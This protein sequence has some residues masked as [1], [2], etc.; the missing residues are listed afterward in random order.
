MRRSPHWSEDDGEGASA[1]P[2]GAGLLMDR[3]NLLSPSRYSSD[4]YFPNG[5][6]FL[7]PS[8]THVHICVVGGHSVDA[9]KYELLLSVSR[10]VTERGGK[11]ELSSSFGNLS[12]GSN[13]SSASEEQQ[14]T[15]RLSDEGTEKSTVQQMPPASDFT[16]SE[17]YGGRSVTEMG[18]LEALIMNTGV[19]VSG[20]RLWIDAPPSTRC[21]WTQPAHMG[22][23][24]SAPISLHVVMSAVPCHATAMWL[25]DH[26]K[27]VDLALVL[28][29]EGDRDSWRA[30]AEID[31]L[32][33]AQPPVPRQYVCINK[34]TSINA[35]VVVTDPALDT[36]D[37][38]VEKSQGNVDEVFGLASAHTSKENLR[39]P[40][41]L[42]LLADGSFSEQDSKTA[43]EACIQV[44]LDTQERGIPLRLRQNKGLLRRRPFVVIPFACGLL[45][46]PLAYYFLGEI[47]TWTQ[48]LAVRGNEWI[49]V[50]I[51]EASRLTH[52][53]RNACASIVSQSVRFAA[54]LYELG[55]PRKFI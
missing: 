55:R 33:D 19:N 26:G 20:C 38:M 54:E 5:Q 39:P 21:H 25:R 50:L 53:L 23:P 11:V 13:L 10:I 27:S 16:V 35:D 1:G 51:P 44:A 46:L 14:D 31:S 37:N 45:G 29:Q 28:F 47:R 32:L 3:F 8:T 22:S 6:H 2:I 12:T 41:R 15:E 30:V 48:G 36:E 18:G 7:P 43:V 17:K 4:V 40:I 42:D 49:E 34:H 9:T 24:F 52:M